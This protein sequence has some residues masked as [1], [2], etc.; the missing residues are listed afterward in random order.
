MKTYPKIDYKVDSNIPIYAFDKLDGSNIRAEWNAKNGFWKFGTRKRLLDESEFLGKSINLIRE[1]YHEDLSRIFY[2]NKYGK[3]ICFFEFWGENS[4][5]GNHEERDNHTVTLIDV[6]PFK[7]GILGPKQFLD[8]VGDLDIP[9]IIYSGRVSP[10]FVKDIREGKVDGVTFE[11]VVCKGMRKKVLVMFKVKS[12]EWITKVKTKFGHDVSVMADLID[13]TELMVE[14]SESYRQRRFCSNCFRSGSLS[15]ICK[16]G[17]SALD[18]AFEA[19]PPRVRASKTRW[20]RFFN[21]W[22]SE[23]DFINCWNNRKEK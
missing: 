6:N 12:I 20:R 19:S 16:C 22:Y 11:G 2:D 15:P 1:K 14:N 3:V 4:F 21:E 9:N 10:S 8:L 17:S 5:A 7:K 23:L 18:M 13:R